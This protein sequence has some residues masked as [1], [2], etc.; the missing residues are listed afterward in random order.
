M[1]IRT[2]A[3][4]AIAATLGLVATLLVR[5]YV[6]R[7]P[8]AAASTPLSPTRPV[9]VAAR[10]IERGE[11]LGADAVKV[12]YY[13]ANAA[14]AG[15]YTTAAAMT[16]AQGVRRALQPLAVNQPI[17]ETEVS[18]PRANGGLSVVLAPGMRAISV[19]TNDVAGVGG[20]VLPGDRVDV[21]VA[22]ATGGDAAVNTLAQTVAQNVR[23]MGVDQ[24]AQSDKPVV[25]K[26]VTLEVTPEQ[27]QSITLAQTVG[28]ISLSLRN[29]EDDA[30]AS[31]GA[32]TVADLGGAKP[33]AAR[34][35][36]R[37]AA[38]PGGLVR[39]TRGVE[40]H[41]YAVAHD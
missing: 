20:F 19:R 41:D 7:T 33:V 24:M 5:S 18:G 37:R 28:A 27:A 26:A 29:E 22:R 21:L 10:A 9:V 39:V 15:A 31:V 2:I 32:T 6:H 35:T 8:A 4:V 3:T 36:A 38:S 13:P 1:N 11:P 34:S 23:V 40:T 30:H 16:S 17:L 12:V 25:T 14:P